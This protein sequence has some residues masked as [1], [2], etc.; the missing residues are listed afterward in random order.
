VD[1]QTRNR[2]DMAIA[3]SRV[4]GTTWRQ[5][6]AIERGVRHGAARRGRVAVASKGESK[7]AVA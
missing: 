4:L 6:N 2:I 5:W 3:A 7:V 1:P